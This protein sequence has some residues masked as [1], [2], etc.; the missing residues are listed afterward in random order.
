V[1]LDSIRDG[2]IAHAIA[3]DDLDAACRYLMD[4]AGIS[5]GDVAGVCFSDLDFHWPQPM[6]T[7]ERN[8]SATGC[9]PSASTP[10]CKTIKA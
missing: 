8:A 9:A 3:M 6:R 2:D 7:S 4:I 5:T 10:R 1:N